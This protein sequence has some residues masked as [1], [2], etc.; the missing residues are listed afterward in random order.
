M[1]GDIP[2]SPSQYLALVDQPTGNLSGSQN[3]TPTIVHS[4]ERSRRQ[5]SQ[6]SQKQRRIRGNDH[7]REVQRGV[8]RLEDVSPGNGALQAERGCKLD[9]YDLVAAVAQSMRE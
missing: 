4:F 6:G 1:N 2:H 3:R 9:A 5:G 8:A 7:V